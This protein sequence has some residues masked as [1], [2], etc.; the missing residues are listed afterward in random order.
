MAR[1]AW[2]L[3]RIVVKPQEVC[4]SLLFMKI[5]SE[6]QV[7]LCDILGRLGWKETRLFMSS[8]TET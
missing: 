5:D 7:S 3:L 2:E 4:I 1:V 8:S 6:N